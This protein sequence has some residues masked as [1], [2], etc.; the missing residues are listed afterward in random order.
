MLE[1]E[2]MLHLHKYA[3]QCGYTKGDFALNPW[4]TPGPVHSE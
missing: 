3:K 2:V 1:Q 4:M